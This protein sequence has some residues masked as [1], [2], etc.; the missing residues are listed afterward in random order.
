MILS[1]KN[2]K[3]ITKILLEL[4][5]N[6]VKLQNTKLTYRNVTFPY[7]NYQEEEFKKLS[8]LKSH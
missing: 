7:T 1:I 6:L 4:I 5:M 8:N 2:P 3:D